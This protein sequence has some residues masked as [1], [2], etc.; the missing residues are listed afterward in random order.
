MD[1]KLVTPSRSHLGK[2]PKKGEAGPNM[3]K[4]RQEWK[5][6]RHV[7]VTP[8]LIQFSVRPRKLKPDSELGPCI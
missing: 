3:A 6:S 7:T 2:E 8:V 5:T 1:S 4:Q